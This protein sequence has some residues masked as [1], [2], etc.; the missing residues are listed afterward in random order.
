MRKWGPPWQLPGSTAQVFR[1]VPI[2]LM[3]LHGQKEEG[4]LSTKCCLWK[5]LFY[6]TSLDFSSLSSASSGLRPRLC[7]GG[8]AG[9]AGWAVIPLQPGEVALHGTVLGLV[10]CGM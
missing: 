3:A 7:A 5:K 8:P 6:H 9:G 2:T 10:S 1:A 4:W